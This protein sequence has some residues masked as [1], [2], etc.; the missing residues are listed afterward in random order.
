MASKT[1]QGCPGRAAWPRGGA[2]SGGRTWYEHSCNR[3]TVAARDA[4]LL[5]TTR[6]RTLRGSGAP[7]GRPAAAFTPPEASAMVGL[8]PGHRGCASQLGVDKC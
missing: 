2:R 7:S 6:M 5:S 3:A 4:A 1:A 8:L